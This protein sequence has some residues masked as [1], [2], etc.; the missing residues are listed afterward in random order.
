[1]LDNFVVKRA[2]NLFKDVGEY[3]L[4]NSMAIARGLIS[5]KTQDFVTKS[6]VTDGWTDGQ[7]EDLMS[8]QTD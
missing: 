6:T 1:M 3:F 2:H 7:T 8:R 5:A 4:K